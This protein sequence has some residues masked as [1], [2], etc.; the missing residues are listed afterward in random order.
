MK[1]CLCCLTI[2]SWDLSAGGAAIIVTNFDILH[3]WS[4]KMAWSKQEVARAL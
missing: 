2:E 4:L 1:P 3:V